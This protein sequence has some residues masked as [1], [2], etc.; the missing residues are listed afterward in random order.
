MNGEPLGGIARTLHHQQFS[1]PSGWSSSCESA[2]LDPVDIELS[3]GKKPRSVDLHESI[4]VAERGDHQ[5]AL[6]TLGCHMMRQAISLACASIL[7]Q[8]E[9]GALPDEVRGGVVFVQFGEHWRQRLARMQLL[10][11]R[12]ILGVHIHDEVGVCSEER[13]LTFRV[14]AIG[15]MRVSLDKL[16]DREAI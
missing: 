8:R 3:L 7:R 9:D 13:H 2:L 14:A 1:W 10:R 6:S 5:A 15:M 4:Q 16:A 12:G 11:R